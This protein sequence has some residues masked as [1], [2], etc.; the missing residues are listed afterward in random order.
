MKDF[1]IIVDA[2]AP[3]A[4][5]CNKCGTKNFHH[6]STKVGRIIYHVIRLGMTQDKIILSAN[7]Y[8]TSH[9]ERIVKMLKY[10]GWDLSDKEIIKIEKLRDPI[11]VY[12]IEKIYPLIELRKELG[13]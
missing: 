3:K 11:T 2:E 1:D 8:N 5:E 12:T 10:H 4:F 13:E 6:D 9:A 7:I